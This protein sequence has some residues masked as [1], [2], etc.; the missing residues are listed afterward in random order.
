MTIEP[1]STHLPL[2]VAA[3]AATE[4]PVIELGSGLYSTPVL[5]GL[6]LA[7][8]RELWTFENNAEWMM[9]FIPRN[10]QSTAQKFS[11]LD[12]WNDLERYGE[13]LK[14]DVAFI[15]VDP[16]AERSHLI[17]VMH[18]WAEIVVV[19]DTE[20]EQRHNYP[21]VDISLDTFR[22]RI[23]DKRRGPWT[24]AASDNDISFLQNCIL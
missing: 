16:A 2:L 7:Q 4:G 14:C 22:Y 21:S 24:T 10:G 5:Q 12:S 19:H 17:D 9:K 8:R 20:T 23:I 1:Y 6:C 11:L 15:D 13:E 3:V 18:R